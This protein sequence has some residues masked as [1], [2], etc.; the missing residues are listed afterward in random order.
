[1]Q[2][3]YVSRSISLELLRSGHGG[4]VP[5]SKHAYRHKSLED[6]IRARAPKKRSTMDSRTSI[7]RICPHIVSADLP[8]YVSLSRRPSS[9]RIKSLA[10]LACLNPSGKPLKAARNRSA[11]PSDSA[12]VAVVS[13]LGARSPHCLTGF[14]YV[15]RSSTL[16][17]FY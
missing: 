15:Q 8:T 7:R 4:I 13:A 6:I 14:A 2:A 10:L 17:T 5:H 1:M 12:Y 11:V 3:K 9:R 16:F